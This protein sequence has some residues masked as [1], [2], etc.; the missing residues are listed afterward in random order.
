MSV[1]AAGTG[2]PGA[3]VD[4]GEGDM[5]G[6]EVGAGRGLEVGEVPAGQRLQ[7]AAQYPPAGAPAANMKASPHLPKLACC[8]HVYWLS[9]GAS[10]QVG[11]GVATAV[12][13]GLDPGVGLAVA[14]GAGLGDVPAGQRLQVAAQYPPAGA[15]AVNIK[16]SPHLPKLACCWH[17]Y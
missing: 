14:T 15:P 3:G 7:V 1:H 16:A 17:V 10:L 6:L 2:L 5:D 13:V 12:A 4:V 8:W 11:T 9:G